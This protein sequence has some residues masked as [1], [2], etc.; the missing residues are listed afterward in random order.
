MGQEEVHSTK[1]KKEDE[2]KWQ[3]YVPGYFTN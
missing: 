1:R 2:E 3:V